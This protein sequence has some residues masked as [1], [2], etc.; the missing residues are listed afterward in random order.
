MKGKHFKKLHWNKKRMIVGILCAALLLTSVSFSS[1]AWYTYEK[2]EVQHVFKGTTLDITLGGED[3]QYDLIPGAKYRLTGDQIPKVTVTK[4]SVPCYVFVVAEYFWYDMTYYDSEANDLIYPID[5]MN[6]GLKGGYYRENDNFKPDRGGENG[7][8]N[9]YGFTDFYAWTE[10][11]EEYNNVRT[12]QKIL[13]DGEVVGKR[14]IFGYQTFK[15][16]NKTPENFKNTTVTADDFTDTFNTSEQDRFVY[17]L[18]G[19]DKNCYFQVMDGIGKIQMPEDT[20]KL[21]KIRYTAYT[22]QAEGLTRD[23]ARDMVCD[24]VESDDMFKY[25][26]SAKT[27]QYT[28]ERR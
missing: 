3:G 7:D 11:A 1:F 23:E 16:V 14:L 24:A 22:V 9:D 27:K 13:L 15:D 4:G 17:I 26:D 25:H 6:R 21:P 5:V 19:N 8:D 2:K 20:T 10:I 12:N 18:E 28:F